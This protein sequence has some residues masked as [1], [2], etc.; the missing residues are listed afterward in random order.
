MVD[1]NGTSGKHVRVAATGSENYLKLSSRMTF[2]FWH[3]KVGV[4]E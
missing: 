3:K 1:S 4:V 2:G